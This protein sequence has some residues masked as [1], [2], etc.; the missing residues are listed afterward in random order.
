M[1]DDSSFVFAGLW[2]GWK[3]AETED[4]LCTSTIITG[5]SNDLVRQIHTRMPAILPEE[6]TKRGYPEKLAKRFW[7]RS[8]ATE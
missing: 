1:K 6:I 2:E 8:R 5:E 7:S 3:P 4:W